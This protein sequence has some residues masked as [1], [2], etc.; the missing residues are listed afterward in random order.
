MCICL[1][2]LNN[3]REKFA[4]ITTF[5]KPLEKKIKKEHVEIHSNKRSRII[6]YRSFLDINK[7]IQ[8]SNVN[9]KRR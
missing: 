7:K 3:W 9:K 8:Q 4:F 6:K 2:I 5:S 1:P